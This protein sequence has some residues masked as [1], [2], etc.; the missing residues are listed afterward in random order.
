V[1]ARH[2]YQPFG[3]EVLPP[4]GSQERIRFAG[5]EHDEETGGG[6]WQALD[7]FGARY[8]HSASGRFTSVDPVYVATSVVDPQLW[9]RYAYTRNNPIRYTDPDGRCIWDACL[10][11]SYAVYM[12]TA[13][14]FT[15]AVYLYSPAG[16]ARTERIANEIAVLATSSSRAVAE[17]A[18]RL[19]E[20]NATD[21]FQDKLNN[22]RGSLDQE[23]LDAALGDLAGKPVVKG[24]RTFDHLTEVQHNLRGLRDLI[25]RIHSRLSKNGLPS[26]EIRDLQR[27]ASESEELLNHVSETLRGGGGG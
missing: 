5:K 7:Y 2:D 14:A 18:N 15:A 23:H 16:R 13:A 1:V 25:G 8:L 19:M 17:L 4:A 27:L 21:A 9:N 12:A 24:G 10:G 26:E 11:E 20:S 22:H 6:A 3:V